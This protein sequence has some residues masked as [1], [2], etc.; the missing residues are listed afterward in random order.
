MSSYRRAGDFLNFTNA[1][2]VCLQHEFGIYGGPSGRHILTLL[3]RLS[4]PVVTHFHTVVAE[5]SADQMRIVKDITRL[6]TRLIVMSERGRQMLEEIYAVSADHIDVIPHGIPDMPFVDPNFYKDQ[7]GVEGKKV[8]LTFGLLSPGKRTRACDSGSSADR[9][10][11]SG[12]RLYQSWER[13][14]RTLSDS[15]VKPTALLWNG[16]Q[17]N[18]RSKSMSSSTIDS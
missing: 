17:P 12:R 2:I 4:L 6:S 7:F 9:A 8:L 13:L 16:W 1:E 15:K 10:G 11:I 14:I 18:S 3:R 5:P